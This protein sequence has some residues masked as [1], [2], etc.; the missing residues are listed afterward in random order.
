MASQTTAL[1]EFADNGNSRT[2]TIQGHTA[3]QPRL[4]IEKRVVPAGEKSNLQYSF[5]VIYGTKDAEG[6]VLPGKVAFDLTV[7]YPVN[8]QQTDVSA[9]LAVLRDIVAGDEFAS[10]IE[11]QGWLN[12]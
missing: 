1:T 9:A 11:T 5:S 8:G 12:A 2:S 10:S 7:R 6:L 3:I 4:V